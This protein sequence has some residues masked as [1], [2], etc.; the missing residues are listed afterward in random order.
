MF[1]FEPIGTHR[2]TPATH[3]ARDSQAIRGHA[4]QR[5]SR[6]S[7]CT[8]EVMVAAAKAT[9]VCSEK[10]QWQKLEVLIATAM[11]EADILVGTLEDADLRLDS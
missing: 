1:G 3:S 11:A 2:D 10:C 9:M 8:K 4:T 7:C 6:S 5:A